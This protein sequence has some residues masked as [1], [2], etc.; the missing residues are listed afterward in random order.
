MENISGTVFILVL[1]MYIWMKWAKADFFRMILKG[2]KAD[3]MRIVDLIVTIIITVWSVNVVQYWS[4]S[5]HSIIRLLIDIVPIAVIIWY[6]VKYIPE[7]H[8]KK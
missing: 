8:A 7:K 6:R 4:P 3:F 5:E 1:H 2:K